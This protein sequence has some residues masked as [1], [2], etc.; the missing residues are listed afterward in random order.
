MG[1]AAWAGYGLLSPALGSTLGVLG[2]IVVG[3]IVYAVL[4]LVLKMVSKDDLALMPKG[5]KIA[6]LLHIK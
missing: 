5:D 4:V 6:R 2:A 3:G 1:A